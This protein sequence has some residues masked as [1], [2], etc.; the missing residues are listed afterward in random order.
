MPRLCG[1]DPYLLFAR[2]VKIFHTPLRYEEGIHSTAVIHESAR[3]GPNASIG[4]Y[5][6]VDRDVAIGAHAVCCRTS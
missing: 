2:V 4:A 3:I 1:E 5:V 6:V